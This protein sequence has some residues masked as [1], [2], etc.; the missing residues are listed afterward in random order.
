MSQSFVRQVD[1]QETRFVGSTPI[2]DSGVASVVTPNPY[3]FDINISTQ[4]PLPELSKIHIVVSGE[5][6]TD[7]NG[8]IYS[9]QFRI[10]RNASTG[11]PS[12]TVSGSNLTSNQLAVIRN[13]MSV[14]ENTSS[15]G[16]DSLTDL[17]FSLT[18]IANSGA[19]FFDI[20]IPYDDDNITLPDTRVVIPFLSFDASNRGP[21]YVNPIIVSV[22]N[23]GLLS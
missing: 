15:S 20:T 11:S 2:Y 17:T 6:G 7:P 9:G 14:V 21:S 16:L 13:A 3:I 18:P 12:I 4:V 22:D 8:T 1:V 10:R 23:D 19:R 5:P